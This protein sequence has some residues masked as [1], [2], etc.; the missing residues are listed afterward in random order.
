MSHSILKNVSNSSLVKF[1]ALSDTTTSGKPKVAND[2]L[3]KAMVAE[4]VVTDVGCT[5]S[6]RQ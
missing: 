4:D 5:S 1:V 6:A 2:R 3:S